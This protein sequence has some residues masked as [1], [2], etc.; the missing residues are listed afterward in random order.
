MTYVVLSAAVLAIIAAVTVPTLR[1]LPLRPLVITA[2]VLIAL[3]AV[4][5][6]IIVG[7]DL[8]AYDESKISGVRVPIA[9]IEDFAYTL[10]AVMLVPALW[11]WL[12]GR[13]GTSRGLDPSERGQD[14]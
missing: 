2:L 1:R 11:T 12:G 13:R 4:F 7:V 10:G 8:V 9:P 3:T 6:N 5:D 14:S